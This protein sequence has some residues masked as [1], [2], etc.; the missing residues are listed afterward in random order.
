MQGAKNT[1]LRL[2]K[3]MKARGGPPHAKN[4]FVRVKSFAERRHRGAG[5]NSVLGQE[6][7]T[8]GKSG[9]YERG[10]KRHK[11]VAWEKRQ[12]RDRKTNN[13][14]GKHLY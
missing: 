10:R 5:K 13:G 6:R 9:P 7:T 1:L 4:L 3:A 2:Y 14:V 12:C 8:K 11:E